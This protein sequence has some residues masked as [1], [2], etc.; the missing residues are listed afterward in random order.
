MIGLVPVT[1]E[2]S[3][4]IS[5]RRER[6]GDHWTARDTNTSE[7]AGGFVKAKRW[8]VI[9]ASDLILNL[10]SVSVVL[11]RRDWAGRSVHSVLER[12]LSVLY[13]GPCVGIIQNNVN[14]FLNNNKS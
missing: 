5:G 6:N 7:T 10:E 14:Q 4:V 8:E 2:N 13:P 12:V 11:P 1:D 3:V 9:E